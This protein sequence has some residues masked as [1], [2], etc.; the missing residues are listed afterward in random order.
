MCAVRRSTVQTDVAVVGFGPVGQLTTLLLGASGAHVLALDR[1]PEPFG[2]PR[3]AVTDDACQRIFSRA[4][5]HVPLHV[6][7]SAAMVTAR[8]RVLPILDPSRGDVPALVSFDQVAL[9]AVL[10]AAASSV[11]D[12]RL[13]SGVVGVAPSGS[14]V[15]LDLDDGSS[16]FARW[17][18][19]CDGARSTVRDAAGIG[20]GG[21]TF[22]EPWLVV[23]A[24]VDPPVPGVDG[25]QF[26]ADPRRPAVTLPLA[27]GLHRWEF[28]LGP[29]ETPDWRELVAPW[30]DPALLRPRRVAVYTYHARVA[31]SWRAGRVLLAGDAAHVMPP[32]A[33]QGLSAGLRDAENLAW[34]LAAVLD[35]APEALLDT[36]EAERRPEVVRSSALA[37]FMGAVLQTRR[38]RL[39][40]ARDA[41]FGAVAATP[42]LG[43]WFAAGG[44][45]PSPALPRAEL[46]RGPGP[47]RGR[48]VPAAWDA[49]LP[50]GW[51]TVGPAPLP[52]WS[53][54]GVPHVP[55]GTR[56]AAIRPDRYVF[57]AGTP[58]AVDRAASD[59]AASWS[60][61]RS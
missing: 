19:G 11:A 22:A 38:R 25:V 47:H 12:V 42:V 1:S 55:L 18:V 54:L 16:V 20:Y 5:L 58:P 13:G 8:G 36:Y 50:A 37:R 31:S 7:A 43:P 17:V 56:S 10:R 40:T 49:Q 35:G 23:D 45:R 52:A 46:P 53:A 27:P 15:V 32:F 59:Y 6:P 57:A 41:A 61:P 51:V 29:G 30:I 21:S 33:G 3:A 26:V 24:A 28:M 48:L 44:L 39:A 4:G 60:P 9:E 14:G 2:A 34:K